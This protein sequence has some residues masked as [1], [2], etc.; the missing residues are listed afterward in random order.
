MGGGWAEP[1]ECL[2]EWDLDHL[3]R[4]GQGED[5]GDPG[6]GSD[7]DVKMEDGNPGC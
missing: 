3:Q 1:L 2:P 5:T 6:A 7:T 4:S